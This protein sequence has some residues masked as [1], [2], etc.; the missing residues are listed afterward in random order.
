MAK[1]QPRTSAP[2]ISNY[3]IE[4]KTEIVNIELIKKLQGLLCGVF[5]ETKKG[6]QRFFL[7]LFVND[8]LML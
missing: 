5:I 2:T 6:Y 8:L 4:K 1:D 7:C 3:S